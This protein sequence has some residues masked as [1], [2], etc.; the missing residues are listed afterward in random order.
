MDGD[1]TTHSRALDYFNYCTSKP[2]LHTYSHSNCSEGE[3]IF[4]CKKG[5]QTTIESE[6]VYI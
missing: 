6:Y 4:I 5:K 2:M 3:L 1:I